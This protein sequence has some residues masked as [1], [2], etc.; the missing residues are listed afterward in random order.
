MGRKYNQLSS[1]QRHL[2]EFMLKQNKTQREIAQEIGVSPSTISRE[3]RRN[4]SPVY[5]KY[6]AEQAQKRRDERRKNSNKK[7][8]IENNPKTMEYVHK[9]MREGWSPEMIEQKGRIEMKAGLLD[10]YVPCKE[11]IYRYIYRSYKEKKNEELIHYLRTR[12]KRR[13]KRGLKKGQ[14]G[15]IRDRV[16]IDQRPKVINERLRIGDWEIDTI[17][18]KGHK[19]VLVS[20]TERVSRILLLRYVPSKS[21][22]EVS[23]AI[24][25]ALAPFYQSGLVK[26]ITFDN[27][28][29]FAL[30]HFIAKK[31]NIS[32]FFTHP[33]SAWQKGT[34][35]R[36][37]KD[38]RYY[39]PKKNPFSD[40]IIRQIPYI[41]NKINHLPRK[42]LGYLSPYEYFF[43]VLSHQKNSLTLPPSS[44]NNL[45]Q[46]KVESAIHKK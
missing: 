30:H 10:F 23:Q 14:R 6:T 42:V 39:I 27:G 40:D 46:F 18:G 2:I 28:K 24:L 16:F 25:N 26:S 36:L 9:K 8:L 11:T 33:Y 45:L 41:E 15:I 20:M 19:G 5:G 35:E 31:W 4:G 1:S 3:I 12:R 44:K 32:T 43:Y 22:N 17:E 29:E 21:A 34:I 7:P 37:N 38:V 13:R